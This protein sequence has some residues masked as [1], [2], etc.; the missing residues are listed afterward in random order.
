V[1]RNSEAP[2]LQVVAPSDF[3]EVTPG[4][5]LGATI[6][7]YCATTTWPDT[8]Q[9]LRDGDVIV[10]TS[11]IVSKAEGRIVA[12]SERES[13]LAEQTSTIVASKK[14]P[15]GITRIVRNRNGVVLAAAGIDASNAPEGR[16]L[17]LPEDPDDS[18]RR[19]RAALRSIHGVCVGVI[20]SDTLGRPWREGLTDAALGV[21]GVLPL[22]DHRGQLDSS[23]I[24]LEVTVIALAD[25]I[26]AAADLIKGKTSGRPIAII[27]G[28]ERYVTVEDGPGSAPLIRDADED[29]FTLGTAEARMMGRCEAA[30]LRRTVRKFTDDPVPADAISRAVAAAV[31]APAPHHTSPWRFVHL[32]DPQ[33]RTQVLNAMRAQWTA[34]LRDVD[35][36]L[37][38]EIERRISRGDMLRRAPEVVFAWVDTSP[39][40]DYPDERRQTAER[41]LFIAAG[42]AGVQNFLISLAA[43]GLG[44]AWISSTMFCPEVVGAELGVADTWLPLG[45]IAI[46][47][48]AQE[49]APRDA[50]VDLPLFRK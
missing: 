4:L 12:V 28:L 17:L 41:D 33:T 29:L 24:A 13:A 6:A 10:V 14:T 36:L 30:S 2:A 8:S 31:T 7:E 3:P 23:G 9:G 5:D 26:A 22:D 45:A 19:I 39:A 11:K 1:T 37:E 44:S 43:E 49:P 27:R 25:E 46:G 42:A 34:D 15:R 38:E 21:A 35:G 32:V 48:P 40:H 50:H 16:L 20:I 47:W 18:A